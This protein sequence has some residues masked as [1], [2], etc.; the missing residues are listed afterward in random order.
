LLD[1]DKEWFDCAQ[2][3][4]YYLWE[5]SGCENALD[6]WYAAEDIACFFEQANILDCQMADSIKKL[7]IYSEG[8]VWF[9]RNISYRLHIYSG[10]ENELTNWFLVERLLSTAA[11]LENITAM[12]KML[13][14]D[15]GEIAEQVRS[16]IVRN[17]YGKQT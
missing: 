6:L 10:N 13:R 2:M 15:S 4:A 11:W 1:I 7:G 3:V 9:V 12:A 8:Y 16:D 17:F 14:T 5:Q